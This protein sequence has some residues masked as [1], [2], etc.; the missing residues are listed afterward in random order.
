MRF[1]ACVAV[2]TLAAVS[3]PAAASQLAEFHNAVEPAYS[4]Y[5]SALF[6]LRTGN[7]MV[8]G[9]ELEQMREHWA[10]VETQFSASPPDAYADDPTFTAVIRDVTDRVR[11]AAESAAGGDADGARATL[12]PIRESLAQL[13]KRAGVRVFSD[14]INEVDA[15][16]DALYV[17]RKTPPDLADPEQVNRVKAGTAVLDYLL[18]RCDGEA[19]PDV[20]GD[21]EFR[22][23]VDG[24]REALA[25]MFK[26]LDRNDATAVVNILR[27]LRSFCQIL[28]LRFG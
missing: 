22:R 12:L 9:F 23:L 14:C 5:R 6:Y 28:F 3:P 21:G 19:T 1:L 17:F 10:G 8:A 7:A 4:S 20:R 24:S 16:M 18:R 13:R 26:A 2:L 15:A 11:Q 27:E 25:N